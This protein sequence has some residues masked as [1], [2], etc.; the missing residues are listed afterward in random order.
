MALLPMNF[1]SSRIIFG[2][3]YEHERTPYTKLQRGSNAPQVMG[4]K[5]LLNTYLPQMITLSTPKFWYSLSDFLLLLFI[6]VNVRIYQLLEISE[7]L[8]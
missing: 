7:Q 6:K 4:H 8:G 1:Q 3:L 2:L 5:Q